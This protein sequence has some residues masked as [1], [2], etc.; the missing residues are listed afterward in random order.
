M[1]W[2]NHESQRLRQIDE[3]V[4][5]LEVVHVQGSVDDKIKDMTETV[6]ESEIMAT[7]SGIM[8]KCSRSVCSH[9]NLYDSEDYANKLKEY[10]CNLSNRDEI[11]PLATPDWS[12]LG[13]TV[14]KFFP[15]TP[16]YQNLLGTLESTPEKPVVN[17]AKA[18]VVRK[19]QDNAPVRHPDTSK[20]EK[21]KDHNK[22]KLSKI[23]DLIRSAKGS[24][25]FFKLVLHP[26]DF[27]KTVDNVLCVAF[28]VR[29]D[30]VKFIL[31]NDG[32][33]LVSVCSD[34]DKADATTS[35]K[36][37]NVLSLSMRQWKELVKAYG[38]VEP[39]IDLQ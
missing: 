4:E 33:P 10:V 11:H 23:T 12:L 8:G 21:I 6:L 15:I 13:K 36:V 16:T 20:N 34:E 2:L 19:K 29:D 32:L 30:I 1:A 39:M 38:I 27:A 24:V 3:I 18:V 14:M 37:Q 28:L 17:A 22:T 7:A 31:D 35:S 26:T 5:E 9:M 25:D